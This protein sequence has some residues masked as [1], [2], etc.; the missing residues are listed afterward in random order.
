M[1]TKRKAENEFCWMTSWELRESYRKHYNLK[2]SQ[3]PSLIDCEDSLLEDL[4]KKVPEVD[5]SLLRKFCKREKDWAIDYVAAWDAQTALQVLNWLIVIPSHNCRVSFIRK[6]KAEQPNKTFWQA[7]E[8]LC[9]AWSNIRKEHTYREVFYHEIKIE[10]FQRFWPWKCVLVKPPQL[11][12]IE[13]RKPPFLNMADLLTDL[14]YKVKDIDI[15]EK[16]EETLLDT[17]GFFY[18]YSIDYV[19]AMDAITPEEILNWML[20]FGEYQR[21]CSV[22]TVLIEQ[23]E[24]NFWEALQR[25]CHSWKQ[26]RAEYSHKELYKDPIKCKEIKLQHCDWLKV[27]R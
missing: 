23:P 3:V 17:N 2:R 10:T 21:R 24:K 26:I 18:E 11:L 16:M 27:E 4:N 9:E 14:M 19:S 20:Y 7:L 8:A 15:Y 22:R 1:G 5:E 12:L 13:R 6:V 25:V